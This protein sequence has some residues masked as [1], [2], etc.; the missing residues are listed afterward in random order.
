M[1][2]PRRLPTPLGLFPSCAMSP[3]HKQDSGGMEQ[4]PAAQGAHTDTRC[5]PQRMQALSG[6]AE[7]RLQKK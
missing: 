7:T 3:Q 6:D 4:E 1:V 5:P 2:P